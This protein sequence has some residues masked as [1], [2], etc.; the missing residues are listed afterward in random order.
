MGDPV[1]QYEAD[2]AQFYKDTGMWCPG[3][4]MPPD[5]D[6]GATMAEREDAWLAWRRERQLVRERDMW[7][8][9]A[10]EMRAAFEAQ[11]KLLQEARD[12]IGHIHRPRDQ[13]FK[14]FCEKMITEIGRILGEDGE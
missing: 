11:R 7:R 2:A 4:S 3:K 6:D 14:D 9:G 13:A 1:D 12:A 8:S 10:L 5:F